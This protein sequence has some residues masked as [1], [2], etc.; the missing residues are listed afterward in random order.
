MHI[1]TLSAL[2]NLDHDVLASFPFPVAVP[3]IVICNLEKDLV[4]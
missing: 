2:I 3:I 1:H 4:I